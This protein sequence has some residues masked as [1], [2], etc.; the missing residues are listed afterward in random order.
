[1]RITGEKLKVRQHSTLSKEAVAS[2]D[3]YTKAL[4][5]TGAG[6]QFIIQIKTVRFSA[7]SG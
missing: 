2:A 4:W 5:I 3:F 6:I 1:M 7:L